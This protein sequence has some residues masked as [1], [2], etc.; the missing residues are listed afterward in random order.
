MKNKL[1]DY[2]GLDTRQALSLLNTMKH[3][4]EQF[5]P[6]AG[7]DVR[8]DCEIFRQ[9]LDIEAQIQRS[10]PFA[11]AVERY[12]AE[13]HALRPRSRMERQQVCR[14][15]LNAHPD[16]A[17]RC[18]CLFGTEDCRRL[19][20]K[21]GF[22]T[23]AARNKARRYLHGLFNY[24][25]RQDWC[26]E[27]PVALLTAEPSREQEIA[28]LSLPQ[29]KQ[30]LTVLRRPEYNACAA[31]VGLML[32]AGIRPQEVARL[33]WRDIDLSENIIS[34][35]PRHTKTGGPRHV[36]IQPVLHRHL[37]QALI[38]YPRTNEQKVVPLNWSKLW[39]DVRAAAGLTPWRPDTLR[40]TFAS[41]HLKHFDDLDALMRDMGHSNP[42]M[43]RTRYL[44]MRGLSAAAAAAFWRFP[45]LPP[46]QPRR[47]TPAARRRYRREKRRQAAAARAKTAS[48][49]ADEA[50][51]GKNEG[52][53]GE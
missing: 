53:E 3:D 28:A 37:V 26:A 33:R 2:T 39:R 31:A 29:V 5:F 12:V 17:A 46:L 30:L 20:Q 50:A 42:D 15:L 41:Y 13:G 52:R 18:I 38:S 4:K 19:L 35:E 27:N 48:A 43:L 45:A 25:V 23:P 21:S 9:G 1:Q 10:V 32:W 44:N 49:G 47:D 22:S 51:N 11:A 36:F 16:F 24:A 14:R 40:H 34:L 8:E 6:G 7:L